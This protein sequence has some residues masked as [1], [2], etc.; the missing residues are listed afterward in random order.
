M[1]AEVLKTECGEWTRG[2]DPPRTTTLTG[3]WRGG[4]VEVEVEVT[5]LLLRFSSLYCRCSA[6]ESAHKLSDYETLLETKVQ[7][8]NKQTNKQSSYYK[9]V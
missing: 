8:T 4:E 5:P 3:G 9:V 7:K 1:A 6:G 2:Q